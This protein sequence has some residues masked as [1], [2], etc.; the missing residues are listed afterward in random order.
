MPL[1][2]RQQLAL[3]A[4]L[5]ALRHRNYRLLFFGQL[6]S[7]CGV[8]MQITAQG[9][10]I[11]RLTNSP[12]WLGLIAAAQSLP[13]VLLSLPAGALADKAPKRTLLLITQSA[14]MI[15]ALL[16][17]LLLY[18]GQIQVWH[19][20]LAAL[21]GGIVSA[22]DN[23]ARQAFTI[24]LVGREDLMNAIALDSMVFNGSRIIG[25]ATAGAL[26]AVI[27]EAPAFLFNG[28]SFLA[29]IVGLL[30]MRLRPFQAAARQRGVGGLREGI[31]YIVGEPKVRLLLLQIGLLCVFGLAYVPLLPSFARDVLHGDAL[32]FG[33][34]AATNAAGALCAALIIALFG[35]R[36]PRAKYMTIALLSYSIL[37]GGF[38]LARDLPP[39]LLLI[40]GVGWA[41]ITSLTISNTL[42]QAI[43]PDQLRGRVMSV[44]VLMVMG[45]SQLSGLMLAA[46]A[47]IVGDVA[48]TV[49]V[50]TSLGWCVLLAVRLVHMRVAIEPPA[51]VAEQPR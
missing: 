43:V 49:G 40:A 23:T 50:W 4:M 7:L 11:L 2:Y 32:V 22:V 44:F 3:P 20:L 30:L 48:L 21:I 42:L 16:L 6:V 26:V 35:D 46:I 13:V 24:E 18:I 27:G 47:D 14:A 15:S 10:L 5:R 9:W 41:G 8:W 28:L 36:I 25:P 17:A 12:L 39:A 29:V 1:I 51:A 19:V 31:A 33:M 34:V 45:V 38:T 37:L